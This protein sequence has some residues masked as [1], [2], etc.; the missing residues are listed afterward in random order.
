MTAPPR[1]FRVPIQAARQ[2]PPKVIS[3]APVGNGHVRVTYALPGLRRAQVAV[4]EVRWQVG[5][6]GSIGTVLAERLAQLDAQAAA[7]GGRV[8]QHD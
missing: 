6:H 7:A 4:P 8:V 1:A 3:N 5:G 2:P